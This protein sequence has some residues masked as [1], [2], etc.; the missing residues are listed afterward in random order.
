MIVAVIPVWMMQATIDQVVDV[1]AMRNRLVTAPG[2]MHMA[3]LKTG[4][5]M[6]RR[7]A[8]RIAVGYLDHM[9]VDMIAVRMVQVT[10]M[11]V[12][13]VV[14]VPN[15]DMTAPGAVLVVMVGVLRMGTRGHGWPPCSASKMS[16]LRHFSR[17]R[18]WSTPAM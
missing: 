4:T 9:L 12:V 11:K 7:A 1:I 5:A 10:V 13:D 15:G 6:L 8:V 2:P 14:A 18:H 17:R 3:G 16:S